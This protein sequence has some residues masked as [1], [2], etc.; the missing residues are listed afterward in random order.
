MAIRSGSVLDATMWPFSAISIF[1]QNISFAQFIHLP[2]SHDHV[3]KNPAAMEKLRCSTTGWDR[4]S[5][6]PRGLG[7]TSGLKL[8]LKNSMTST[9]TRPE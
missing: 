4:S 9:T 7:L 2:N 1:V 8:P 5:L 6:N 3:Y